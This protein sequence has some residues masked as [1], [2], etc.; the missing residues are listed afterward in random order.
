MLYD[1]FNR[2]LD[3]V[4]RQTQQM[5]QELYG[6]HGQ[7]GMRTE[8]KLLRIDQ[9]ERR[10]EAAAQHD[11]LSRQVEHVQRTLAKLSETRMPRWLT[12]AFAVTFLALVGWG[13]LCA[14][15]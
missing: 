1:T 15:R 12:I 5:L 8:L 10:K 11:H 9:E 4:E 13:T 6:M 3:A 2:R 14:G 7:D